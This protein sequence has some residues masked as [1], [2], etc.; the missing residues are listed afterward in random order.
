MAEPVASQPLAGRGI[1]ITRPTHQA[2]PLAARIRA[3]G[4]T[5]ILFPALEILDVADPKRL[6]ALIDRLDEFELAIFISP[7]AVNKAMDRITA[8]RALPR[9]LKIAAVGHGSSSELARRG[10]TG[11]IVPDTGF[12]SEAL[13]ALSDLRNVAGMRIVV[14]RGEGGREL[15]G[16]TLIAR[17]ASLEYAECYRRGRPALDAAPLLRAWTRDELHAVIVTSGEAVRNLF[18]MVGGP[19]RIRLRETPLFASHARIA[20]TARELGFTIVIET[21]GGDDGLVAGLEQY[22]RGSAPT[23]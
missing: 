20:Q 2:G 16:D 15:L 17:G 5:P 13:L 3:A 9:K 1:V 21:A 18:D 8:R 10:V 22:F 4:G 11:V 6:D 7:N 14:F 23:Q 12:D 19:G